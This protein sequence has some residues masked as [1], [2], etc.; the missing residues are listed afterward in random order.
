MRASAELLLQRPNDGRIFLVTGPNGS[1]KTRALASFTRDALS[2]GPTRIGLGGR[3]VCLSGTV[4]DKFPIGQKGGGYAYFG[5]RTNSNMFSEVAPYRRLAEFIM[6]GCPD[7]AS[8]AETSV[9][10]LNS[11]SL[12]G[13]ISFRFRR[14]RNTKELLSREDQENLD[15]VIDLRKDFSSQRGVEKRLQQ[16]TDGKVHVSGVSFKKDDRDFDIAELSSGE[17]SYALSILAAA[18]SVVDDS[19]LIYDEPENSL[20]P[21]WQESIVRDLWAI[22]SA[23][24]KRSSIIIATHSPLIVAGASNLHTY[25]LD[26]ESGTAWIPSQFFGNTSD[27]VLREQFGLTSARSIAFL[28]RL[29]DCL[30]AVVMVEMDPSD[31]IAAADELLAM[32]VRLDVDDPLFHTVQKIAELRGNLP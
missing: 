5:R 7:W 20:H 28:R 26:L 2:S 6:A 13:M 22:V 29:G 10:L 23:V 15:I 8:R 25:V 27:T 1:G 32:E 9:Q 3:V 18:F 19:L 17:R 4:L 11:I 21:K 14:G 12:E 24:S 31:F 16:L 30:S